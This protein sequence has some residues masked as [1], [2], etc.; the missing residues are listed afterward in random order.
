MANALSLPVDATLALLMAMPTATVA[1]ATRAGDPIIDDLD[2]G[3]AVV[4]ELLKRVEAATGR[5]EWSLEH[6]RDLRPLGEVLEVARLIQGQP[7]AP[8]PVELW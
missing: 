4:E 8:A 1:R 5:R 7:T 2:L 3:P 6:Y